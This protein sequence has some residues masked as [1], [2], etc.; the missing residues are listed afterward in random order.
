MTDHIEI[1]IDLDESMANIDPL[2][3]LKKMGFP[4]TE[5]EDLSD[6]EKNVLKQQVEYELLKATIN[7]LVDVDDAAMI[8]LV[9]VFLA[10]ATFFQQVNDYEEVIHSLDIPEVLKEALVKISKMISDDGSGNVPFKI[11]KL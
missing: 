4:D 3:L 2:E 10:M 7:S 5:N 1:D 11:V 9:G 6:A 8:K